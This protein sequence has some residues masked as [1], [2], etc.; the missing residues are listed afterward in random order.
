M[1]AA[2]NPPVR[3]RRRPLRFPRDGSRRV[4]R[5][6]AAALAAAAAAGGSFAT[7]DARAAEL[8]IPSRGND[9]VVAEIAPFGEADVFEIA[10]LAG[11]TLTV[12]IRDGGTVRGLVPTLTLT[13]PTGA[14]IPI[15]VSGIGKSRQSFKATAATAGLHEIKVVGKPGQFSGSVGGYT[16]QFA[17]KHAKPAKGSFA[18]AGGGSIAHDF[19]A[20]EGSKVT[21]KAAT[22]KGG[23]DLT[24]LRRPDGEVEAGFAAALKTK[25]NRRSA[26]VTKLPLTGATGTYRVEGAYDAGSKVSLTVTVAHGDTKRTRRLD[27]EPRFDEQFAPF[28]NVGIVGTVISVPG[29]DFTFVDNPTPEP[30]TYPTFRV[31]G[32]EVARA[33]VSR[34]TGGVF[35]FPIP[36]GLAAR[37]TYSIEVVNAD[38]QGAEFEDAFYVAP[39]PTATSVAAIDG[40]QVA[41]GPDGGRR[42]RITGVDFRPGT[43]VLFG[44]TPQLPTSVLSTRIDVTAPPHEAGNVT[45]TVRDE[46]GQTS[47]VPGSFPYLDVPANKLLSIDRTF[48]QA[49]G[50][51][52]VTATGTDFG[53]DSV[54]T[55]GGADVGA[56]RL[57]STQM[58]FVAPVRAGATYVLRV[59]D[60][61]EQSSSMNVIVKGFTDDTAARIPAPRTTTGTVDGWRGT[62]VLVGNVDGSNGNDLV[63]L[64]S[65]TALGTSASRSRVR[66]LLANPDGTFSDATSTWLPA[67]SGDE[68][69]RAQDGALLDLDG[70]SDLDLA[71][72]TSDELSSR[73]SLRLLRNDGA[74][75]G[76]TDR[77]SAWAPAT[78]SYGDR[79]QGVALVALGADL[80]IAHTAYFTE[81]IETIIS[82][83]DSTTIPPTP[84]TILVTF[85]HY[86]ALRVL[87][88]NGSGVLARSLSAVPSVTDADVQQYQ[89]DVLVAADV[90]GGSETDL[91]LTRTAPPELPAGTFHRALRV[92]QGSGSSFTDVS[93]S[94][95]PS[96]SDPEYFQGSRI[97]LADADGDTDLDI[98]VL[99]PAAVS[100]PSGSGVSVTALRL[101]VNTSGSFATA[102]PGT[103]PAPSGSDYLQGADLVVGDLDG[104]GRPEIVVIAS[105]APNTGDRACRILRGTPSG[106][107]DASL[108]L[109]APLAG[110]DGRGSG[111]ALLDLNGDTFLDLVLI[112]ND[113]DESVRN[114]RVFI[115]PR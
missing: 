106:W 49:L 82:P 13:G 20:T 75:T 53:T 32:I 37:G 105:Y 7:A 63:L 87:R 25:S 97:A 23:F 110:D 95:L 33:N 51:E 85:N 92:L 66:V 42:L 98:L 79:N 24:A 30:D 35:Q 12:R 43:L 99:A 19:A 112:R 5:A 104:A 39:P 64:Q 74:S 44:A 73:S 72:I 3:S 4:R 89:A 114:T 22:R 48:V 15:S 84:P 83:G 94:V 80:A 93:S 54:L 96:A 34:P 16:L 59:A 40:G 70:D 29:I 68:D 27:P 14:G 71:L 77:T 76:F 57:S 86:P 78:T 62:R 52:T 18:D 81:R 8:P 61:L 113:A 26:K 103:F 31:G 60:A 65:A 17:V 56:Q 67:V 47:V 107:V 46:N 1:R 102:A 11:D 115:N 91:V 28:P 6:F 69:W 9:T 109:P 88:N 111:G 55:L 101:L 90:V 58:T 50:G 36:A 45:L 100:S 41:A 21:L 38:G 2:T 10:L 108:A